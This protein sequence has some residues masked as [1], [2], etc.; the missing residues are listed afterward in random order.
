FGNISQRIGTTDTFYVSGSATGGHAELGAAHFAKV[1]AVDA[2]R[3]R[4][5]C[6]GPILASSESMSH[7]VLYEQLPWV[8]GVIHIH[9]LAAWQQLLHQVPTTDA[10]APY[11]SPEMVRSIATL[12]QTTDLPEQRLF[13]MEGHR[14]GIFAFGESL[15]AAF[16]ILASNLISH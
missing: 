12:L 11:G 13:V 7:A 10:S 9:H 1:T 14:E 15:E 5:W 4:L 8:R 16:A 2:V 6:S 3:N